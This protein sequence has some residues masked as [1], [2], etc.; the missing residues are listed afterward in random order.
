MNKKEILNILNLYGWLVHIND[1]GQKALFMATIESECNYRNVS[2]SL[3]YSKDR[4]KQVFGIKRFKQVEH[5]LNDDAKLT[6]Q[7]KLANIVYSNRNGNGSK[8][9]NDGWL[10]RGRGFFQ[11]TGRANYR[12]INRILKDVFLVDIDIVANPQIINKSIFFSTLTALAYWHYRGM[13]KCES[14][15]CITTLINPKIN[16][17]DR[18]KRVKI[19]EKLIKEF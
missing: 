1:D 13:G 15:D 3:A 16:K 9:T 17:S 12:E 14:M 6:N 8:Y 2:E 19:Y 5:L 7:I 10:Y 18:L 11:L 4:F